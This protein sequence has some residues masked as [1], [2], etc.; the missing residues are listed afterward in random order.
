LLA[1][2]NQL[3]LSACPGRAL[4][5]AKALTAG[6]DTKCR[7]FDRF[8]EPEQQTFAARSP[9]RE[10]NLTFAAAIAVSGLETNDERL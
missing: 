7:A 10:D 2:L 4:A 9:E 8:A 1:L 5:Q 6:V 3:P